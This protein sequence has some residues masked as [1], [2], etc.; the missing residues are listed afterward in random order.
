[1][2]INLH[3]QLECDKDSQYKLIQLTPELLKV[4]KP[5]KGNEQNSLLQFKALDDN[6]SNVVL[7]SRDKTWIVRQKN[8]SNT[9][10]LMNEFI[11]GRPMNIPKESLFGLTEPTS[12]LLGYSSTSFEYETRKTEGQL[13]LDLVPLYNGEVKFPQT[14]NK[15]QL[16]TF[17][18][19]VEHSPTSVVEAKTIWYNVGGCEINGYICLLSNEFMSRA[20]HVMLTSVVAENLNLNEL[21]LD[22]TFR[23]VTKDMG[24]DFNPYTIEVVKT[25][26]NR[27]MKAF[28]DDRW[29]L[30]M[31]KIAKWYGINAL[32]NHAHKTSMSTDEFMIKWKS[33][34]PPFLPCDIDTDMLRGHYY[35]PAEHH[36][37]YIAKN[38]LPIDVKERFNILF[39]LQSTWDFEDIKPL[40]EDL[41]V[42]GLKIDNFIMKYARRRRV[43][44]KQKVIVTS[45]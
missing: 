40:V 13:N 42:H 20:L 5:T 22:E 24:P 44:G 11:P 36:L 12:D 34:F 29:S 26:L 6:S 35:K 43:P 30:D 31:L 15:P 19:L 38:T 28:T 8:H 37:Q 27:F 2:S 25:V 32:K 14:G 41:N 39:R 9:A 16:R 7:C 3:C 45:R 23:A 17:E 33:T 10:L 18:E 4:L 1:M 21:A